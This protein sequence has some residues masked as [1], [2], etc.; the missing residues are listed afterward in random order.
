MAKILIVDDNAA[1]RRFLYIALTS[2]DS[3]HDIAEASN[4]NDALALVYSHNPDIVLADVMM[5]DFTGKQLLDVIK[6]VPTL[7]HIKVALISGVTNLVKEEILSEL[8]PDAFFTK[9]VLASTIN[10]WVDNNSI[11]A[12]EALR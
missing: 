9:P 5:P 10:E 1:Y 2:H 12:L 6:Y 8:H 7:N 11:N 4:G 3:S